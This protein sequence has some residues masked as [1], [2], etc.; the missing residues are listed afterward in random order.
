MLVEVVFEQVAVRTRVAKRKGM[1][2][3]LKHTDVNKHDLHFNLQ[4]RG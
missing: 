3:Y 1:L 4:A 2:H